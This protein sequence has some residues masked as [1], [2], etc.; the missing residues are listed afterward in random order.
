MWYPRHLQKAV[1]DDQV[2]L[3]SEQFIQAFSRICSDIQRYLCIFSHIQRASPSLFL[4]IEKS[5]LILEKKA[6]VMS[7]FW[8]NFPFKM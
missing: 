5:I 2:Y 7:I 4:K 1:K 6:L 8:L 3:E